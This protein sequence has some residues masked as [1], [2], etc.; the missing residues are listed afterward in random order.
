M[1]RNRKNQSVEPIKPEQLGI[2]HVVTC[3]EP[4]RTCFGKNLFLQ[5]SRSGG[6]SWVFRYRRHGKETWMGLGAVEHTQSNLD[7]AREAASLLRN[8]RWGEDRIDPLEARRAK[9]D[10]QRKQELDDITFKAAATKFLDLYEET[11]RNEKHRAQ[12]RNTLEVHAY[13]MLGTR[14]VRVIDAALI[15]GTLAP[16]WAKTPETASRVK[17]RIE[18]VVAWVRE[19]MPLPA[20]RTTKRVEHHAA[21]PYQEIPQFMAD[22]RQKEGQSARALEF[23][24][25]C[26]SRTGEVI[27]GRWPEIL[28]NVWTIP[29]ERMK[30]GREHKVP[31]SARALAIL[32]GLPREEGNEFI[33]IGGREGKGL[34][35]MA[36]LQLLK[37]MGHDAI[38]VHGMRSAFKDWA[39][40][41]TNFPDIASE[42]AL[43]HTIKSK[44]ERAYRRGDLLLKRTKL[45]EAWDRYCTTPPKQSVSI[46][47]IQSIAA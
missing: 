4:G 1:A 41:M 22:L 3:I 40:E 21:L 32:D 29:G 14:P 38:T 39:S 42:M 36:M 47:P 30:G 23:L 37:D 34:S 2:E 17:Q 7:R 20:P 9:R 26:A 12:W 11:W 8:Q 24:I 25:L 46:M 5:V 16:I 10:A 18:R 43:A 13:P 33:F 45:M 27:G 35:N 19:G 44:V 15:N 31:L 28:D 6:R